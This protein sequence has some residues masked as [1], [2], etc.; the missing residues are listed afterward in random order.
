MEKPFALNKLFKLSWVI[1]Q[2]KRAIDSL[3]L[4]RGFLSSHDQN[5]GGIINN[6]GHCG[7]VLDSSEQY[8]IETG[9]KTILAKYQ[10]TWANCV[11]MP[12]GRHAKV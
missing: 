5:F 2:K 8:H 6:K 11:L 10:R 12:R 3:N 4:L 1:V 9:G 7:E